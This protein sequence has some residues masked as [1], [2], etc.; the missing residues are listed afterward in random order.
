MFV[1]AIN[2]L[3]VKKIILEVVSKTEVIGVADEAFPG[4]GESFDTSEDLVADGIEF[5]N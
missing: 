5:G 3:T 2:N 4:G 1:L